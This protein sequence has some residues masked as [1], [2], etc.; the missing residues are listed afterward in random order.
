M[1]RAGGRACSPP[2]ESYDALSS[3]GVHDG[4][5]LA[6]ERTSLCA[7]A[8]GVPWLHAEL[9]AALHAQIASRKF[10]AIIPV[11]LDPCEVPLLLRN[12]KRIEAGAG[13]PRIAEE[14]HRALQR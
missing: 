9:E 3:A 2:L 13:A 10:D 5:V 14:I 7:L 11:V 8:A 12:H 6:L 4:D 1:W